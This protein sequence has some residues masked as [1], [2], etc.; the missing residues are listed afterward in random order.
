M[1]LG[2]IELDGIPDDINEYISTSGSSGSTNLLANLVDQVA[3][4][5]EEAGL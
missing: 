4:Q 1:T 3:D 5:L 2:S